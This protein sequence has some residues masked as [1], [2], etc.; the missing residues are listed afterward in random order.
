MTY[1][2]HLTRLYCVDKEKRQAAQRNSCGLLLVIDS[3]FLHE[4]MGGDEARASNYVVG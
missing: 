2:Q 3:K 1:M 4:I